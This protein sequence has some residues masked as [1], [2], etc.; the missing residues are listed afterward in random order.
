MR[1]VSDKSRENQ[2]KYF[3]QITFF[4]ENRVVYEKIWKNR[5]VYEKIWKNRVV[6]EKI[7]KNV[8]E[9]DRTQTTIQ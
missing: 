2:S 8:V 7:W 6:Y 4:F 9:P 3:V 5:V 1:N